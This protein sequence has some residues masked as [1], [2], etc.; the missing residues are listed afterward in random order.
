MLTVMSDAFTDAVND[1][2]RRLEEREGRKIS[3]NQLAE[4]AGIP[5][6]T[7][8]H[9][10]S[11]SRKAESRRIPSELVRALAA[12]L[13]VSEAD[14]SRAAQIANGYTVRDNGEDLPDLRGTLVRYLEGAPDKTTQMRTI[15][16]VQRIMAEEMRRILAD[17]GD[18]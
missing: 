4:L 3:T 14:L 16:E 5:K 9:H 1:A 6:A 12:V 7:L 15:A 8:H 18:H 13:P 11:P 2:R 17:N 10:I